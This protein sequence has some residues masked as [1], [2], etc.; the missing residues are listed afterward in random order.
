MQSNTFSFTEAEFCRFMLK[1]NGNNELKNFLTQYLIFHKVE[2]IVCDILLD[3]TLNTQNRKTSLLKILD[4]YIDN[5]SVD[6]T[7]FFDLVKQQTIYSL[8]NWLKHLNNEYKS[9][10]E[11][12]KFNLTKYSQQEIHEAM[13]LVCTNIIDIRF[14]LNSAVVLD[15]LHF[16][17]FDYLTSIY[18]HNEIFIETIIK[19]QEQNIK[20]HLNLLD[21]KIEEECKSILFPLFIENLDY[22]S[23]IPSLTKGEL[24]KLLTTNKL[25]SNATKFYKKHIYNDGIARFET[26]EPWIYKLQRT[27]NFNPLTEP[28]QGFMMALQNDITSI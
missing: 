5:N 15:W 26:D 19:T 11:E 3:K 4:K 8:K 10:N 21:P 27:M 1:V 12:L 18:S 7:L 24:R 2:S 16:K 6:F 28:V 17:Y 13:F 25:S 20:K 23:Q 14:L 22:F 9:M